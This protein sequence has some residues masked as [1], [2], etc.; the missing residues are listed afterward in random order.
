M[1]SNGYFNN[2]V[3][4]ND[5]FYESHRSLVERVLIDISS[6]FENYEEGTSFFWA[7][8]LSIG[9]FTSSWSCF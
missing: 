1:A 2:L 8:L 5:H 4:L 9:S 7:Y 3:A 6:Q